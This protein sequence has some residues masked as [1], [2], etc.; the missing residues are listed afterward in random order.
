MVGKVWWRRRDTP[1]DGIDSLRTV[2]AT[3][4]VIVG[5]ASGVV[6]RRAWRW[7][8]TDVAAALSKTS[9]HRERSLRW[10]RMR[11]SAIAASVSRGR[12]GGRDRQ[13]RELIAEQTAAARRPGSPDCGG[14]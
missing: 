8:E 14:P 3:A 4:T 1:I 2:I 12:D 6:A 5:V 9:S 13:L 11:F 7:Q 10:R